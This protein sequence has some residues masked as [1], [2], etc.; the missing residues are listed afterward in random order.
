[1]WRTGHEYSGVRTHQ[2]NCDLLA[3][4][5]NFKLYIFIYMYI[6]TCKYIYLEIINTHNASNMLQMGKNNARQNKYI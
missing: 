1:L 3:L 2:A 6:Y 4:K 5:R